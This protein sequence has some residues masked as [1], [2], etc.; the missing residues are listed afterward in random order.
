MAWTILDNHDPWETRCFPTYDT[1]QEAAAEKARTEAQC[2]ADGY[3][4][5]SLSVVNT[6]DLRDQYSGP[7][8]FNAA[9]HSYGGGWLFPDR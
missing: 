6:A 9:D 4:W 3:G 2:L 1:Q 5:P 8:A 7:D